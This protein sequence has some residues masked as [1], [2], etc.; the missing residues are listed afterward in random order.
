MTDPNGQSAS[1]P[2][3][4]AAAPHK[5]VPAT[6]P[7]DSPR[8]VAPPDA[9]CRFCGYDIAGLALAAQCP[10]CGRSIMNSLRGYLF[11]YADPQYLRTLRLGARILFFSIIFFSLF[12]TLTGFYAAFYGA[13]LGISHSGLWGNFF[14]TL[15]GHMINA[16]SSGFIL[17]QIMTQNLGAY[18]LLIGWALLSQRDPGATSN[19]PDQAARRFLRYTLIA[20][21]LITT[22]WLIVQLSPGFRASLATFTSTTSQSGPNMSPMSVFTSSFF[23]TNGLRGISEL[24]VN[25]VK[26]FAALNFMR[27]LARRIPDESLAN[28]AGAMRWIVPISY[29]VLSCVSGII[30]TVV[31]AVLL[32]RFQ[33]AIGKAI[34]RAE[35][36]ATTSPGS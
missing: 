27:T 3:P 14:S 24:I 28:L 20:N 15:H 6:P 11:E 12:E 36:A 33:S 25:I 10:E 19:D 16:Q 21:A 32:D 35:A 23:I 4:A 26:F 2:T 18:V 29:V 9:V 1:A 13:V 31:Y 34:G 17:T 22:F 30:V 7:T 5:P 8:G